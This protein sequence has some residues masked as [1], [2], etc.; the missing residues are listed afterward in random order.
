MRPLTKI[1][2]DTIE[3]EI[4]P[5]KKLPESFSRAYLDAALEAVIITAAKHCQTYGVPN[6]VAMAKT[7]GLNRNTLR[8]YIRHLNINLNDYTSVYDLSP[9]AYYARRKRAELPVD[10]KQ[11]RLA[12]LRHKYF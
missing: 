10:L 7:L 2:I 9:Q 11:E 1:I 4:P 6:Q 12:A 8:K 5:Y 3:A